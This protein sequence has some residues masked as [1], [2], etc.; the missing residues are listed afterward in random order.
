MDPLLLSVSGAVAGA[1]S[2]TG[3]W[4]FRQHAERLGFID[5][6]NERSSHRMPTPRAGGL[7]FV[8]V[9]PLVVMATSRWMG[10]GFLPGE[11][12]LLFGSVVV[13]AV[14]LADDRWG[15]PVR[16]RF[17]VYLL[18]AAVLVVGGGYL[19]ELQWPGGPSIYLGWLGMPVTLFWVVGL[20]NAYNFMDGIDGIAA[21]QAVVAGT[22]AGL[23]ALWNGSTAV[24]L[25]ALMLAAGVLGFIPH[26]WPPARIFM[27]DVGSA[28]LGYTFAGLAVLSSGEPSNS[29][30]F[31]L[32]V[33]L[34]AP[35]LFDTMLT[36]ARRVAR[37]EKW[38]EA[39]RQHLYQRL[40][41]AGWSHLSV[42]SLYLC[43]DLLLA[44]VVVANSAVKLDGAGFALVASLPLLAIFGLVKW[45]ERT[46]AGHK[47]PPYRFP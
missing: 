19:H 40:V 47:T 6:P 3:V 28:F 14:G 13:A 34:L 39:H 22:A 42:T 23:L 37:G 30:P 10:V 1:L 45:V 21:A 38:F 27:G 5:V 46:A 9:A 44:V 11:G 2:W 29:I 7:A 35:F 41:R 24:G 12:A 15:L 43:A 25:Y 8:A 33:V 36:L 4:L 16:L 31:G 26:N 18:A 20:T 17:A 32:W